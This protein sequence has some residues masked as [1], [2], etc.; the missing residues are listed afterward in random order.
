VDCLVIGGSTLVWGWGLWEQGQRPNEKKKFPV[1]PTFIHPC[2]MVG[3]ASLWPWL[4]RRS[5]LATVIGFS[6]CTRRGNE[7]FFF[8]A[9]VLLLVLCL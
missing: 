1:L 8:L 7:G 5:V 9:L 4:W 3:A 6:C 2:G